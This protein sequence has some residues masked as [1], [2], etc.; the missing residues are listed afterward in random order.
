L[1]FFFETDS[2][3]LGKT[4]KTLGT[5]FL[6]QDAFVEYK[7]HNVF[8]VDDGL[9]L[10]PFSRNTLQ[11]PASYYTLDVSPITT[12]GNASTQSSALRDAGFGAKGFFLKDKLQYRF[13]LFQGARDANARSS[14]RTAGYLQ[15]DFFDTETA[16][17]FPGTALGKRKILAVDA[18]FD[19]QGAYRAW[20]GNIA[21]D[22]PVGGGK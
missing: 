10:V 17:T 7:F 4:P 12:V 21:T 16:Y 19:T 2:P 9:M 3:N 11:S 6:I 18:G 1:T 15:Y 22:V 5:G 14:L 13:G 8:R 20:S